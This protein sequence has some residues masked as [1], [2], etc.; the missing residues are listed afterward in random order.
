M[1]LGLRPTS[2]PRV[3][4]HLSGGSLVRGCITLTVRLL[5]PLHLLHWVA[6]F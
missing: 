4:G 1:E 5:E 2:R 6:S 3:H